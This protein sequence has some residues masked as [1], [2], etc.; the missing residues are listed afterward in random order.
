MTV[1]K[2]FKDAAWRKGLKQKELEAIAN[3]IFSE[4]PEL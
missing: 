3:S 4:M 2:C 1:Q